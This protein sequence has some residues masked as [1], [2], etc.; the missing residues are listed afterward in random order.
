MTE[1]IFKVGDKVYWLGKGVFTLEQKIGDLDFPL[2]IKEIGES[3]TLQGRRWKKD[4][5]P[6]LLTM[7]QARAANLPGARDPFKFETKVEW[8]HIEGRGIAALLL[9]PKMYEPRID[10]LGKI[11]KLTFVEDEE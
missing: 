5:F 7:E 11:G 6:I 2:M 10:I 8:I 4:P 1:H 9:I 3:F